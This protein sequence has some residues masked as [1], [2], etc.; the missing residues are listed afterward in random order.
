MGPLSAPRVAAAPG[1]ATGPSEL[2]RRV[3]FSQE[4]ARS[5]APN[6]GYASVYPAATLVKIVAAQLLVRLL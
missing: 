4:Q 3:A 5:E 1:A 2:V 6:T